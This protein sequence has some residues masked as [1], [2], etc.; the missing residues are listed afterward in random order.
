MSIALPFE[1]FPAEAVRFLADLKANNERAWFA[2]HRDVY[3]RSLKAPGEAFAAA[4]TEALAELTGRPHRAKVFRIHRDVRFSKDKRPYNAHLHIGFMTDDAE[5]GARGYALGWYFGLDPERV[6]LGAGAFDFDGP[7]LDRFRARAAGE[8]GAELVQRLA[9]LQAGGVRL[10]P[11]EL[12]RT[13][14]G[15]APDHPRADLLRRKGLTVWIDYPDPAV[16]TR[17][18]AVAVMARDCAR[19]LPVFE[20]LAE[21]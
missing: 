20:W 2:A 8:D 10:D 6:G 18:D 21:A 11:P 9:A 4:M 12:K 17:A 19:L 3:E 16:V 14:A 15:Y 1:G 5:A 7:A 13:P